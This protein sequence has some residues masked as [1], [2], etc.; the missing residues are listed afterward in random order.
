MR[1][2]I[3]DDDAR[4]RRM[5]K[6]VVAD[7][8]DSVFEC[9]DGA[10]ASASY[11]EHEPDWVLMDVTMPGLDGISATREIRSSHPTARII[12]VTNHESAAM[13]AEATSAGAYGYLLKQD[14]L[15][16]P[17]ILNKSERPVQ[18]PESFGILTEKNQ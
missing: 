1:F 3:V 12:I 7:D 4:I 8:S 6:T 9:G 5:I 17:G 16:L 13:R 14:L 11:T 10:Q 2:L 18:A 15:E